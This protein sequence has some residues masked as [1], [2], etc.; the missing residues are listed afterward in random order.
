MSIFGEQVSRIL[1]PDVNTSTVSSSCVD[2]QNAV[3]A[4]R[5][6]QSVDF[7]AQ[8]QQLLAGFFKSF[9]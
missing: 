4:G 9:H 6:P 7:F 3:P 1:R 5:L 8:R 2:E